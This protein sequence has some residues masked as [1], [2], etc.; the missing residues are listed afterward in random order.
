MLERTARKSSDTSYVTAYCPSA[1]YI[2]LVYPS[3]IYNISLIYNRTTVLTF[4]AGLGPHLVSNAEQ[5]V[6]EE[7][8]E[9]RF[10]ELH[11]RD[12]LVEDLKG[13]ALGVLGDDLDGFLE[14]LEGDRDLNQVL[15]DLEHYDL[16]A[17]TTQNQQV[18]QGLQLVRVGNALHHGQWVLAYGG[19]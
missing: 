9:L 11:A 16:N 12:Y 15:D 14:D 7:L 8:E 17:R 3:V 13:L 1:I 6:V 10:F 2:I 4:Y 18:Q 5:V 19:D